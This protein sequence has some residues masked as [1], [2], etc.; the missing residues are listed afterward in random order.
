MRAC[1]FAVTIFI[2]TLHGNSVY[3]LKEN[4]HVEFVADGKII[5]LKK[6]I[7]QRAIST[8][9]SLILT[10]TSD[11]VTNANTWHVPVNKSAWWNGLLKGNHIH[12]VYDKPTIIIRNGETLAIP[13]MLLRLQD[14]NFGVHN[15]TN[16]EVQN[17]VGFRVE[18]YTWDKKNLR[19]FGGCDESVMDLLC[20]ADIKE[21]LSGEGFLEG[22]NKL[23][24][25][26]INGIQNRSR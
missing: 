1:F 23:K 10:C 16:N 18:V 24:G 9:E 12:V 26:T 20:N 3:A 11:S 17:L 25:Q 13:E 14:L 8:L 5:P 15:M 4:N 7:K 19:G 21:H 22:C 2:I 6:E